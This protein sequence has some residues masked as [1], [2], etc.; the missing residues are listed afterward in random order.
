[1]TLS[2]SISS[3]AIKGVGVAAKKIILSLRLS[4]HRYCL[5]TRLGLTLL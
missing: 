3:V 5:V 2:Q 4:K 1:M